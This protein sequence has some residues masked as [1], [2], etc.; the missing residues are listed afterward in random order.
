MSSLLTGSAKGAS[1]LIFIQVS[2]RALTFGINQV[3]LRYLSPELLGAS[4][5]LELYSISVLFFSRESLR[6]ALQR[7]AGPLQAIINISALPVLFAIPLAAWLGILYQR[8]TTLDAHDLPIALQIYG[9]A[10]L[11]ELLAEPCFAVVQ[12]KLAYGLRALAE[13]GATFARC[14]VTFGFVIWSRNSSND[15]GVLPFAFGQLAYAATLLVVYLVKTLPIMEKE[16]SSY[17]PNKITNRYVTSHSTSFSV[18]DVRS[19]QP[20]LIQAMFPRTVVT[21]AINMYLQSAVKYILTQGDSII[22]ASMASLSDQGAYALASN[23][24]GLIA[25]MLFQPIEESSRN[26]FAKLC[27]SAEATKA[28]KAQDISRA[29]EVLIDI[30]KVYNLLALISWA[31]GPTLAPKMLR[32]VAGTKWSDTGAGT[33][34]GIYCYYIPFLAANGVTEAFVSAVAGDKELQ[35]QSFVLVL[36]SVVF[37]LMAYVFLKFYEMGASG[38]VLANC[39]NMMFRTVWNIAFVKRYFKKNGNVRLAACSY[40]VK[41]LWYRLCKADFTLLGVQT[42]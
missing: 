34:L 41:T 24:G 39:C 10:T 32:V 2:S 42:P 7:H 15:A 27:A 28:S 21:T 29:K 16:R 40:G 23:Y 9:A 11:I 31:V 17:V 13:M 22:I 18:S 38:L 5:Q 20:D 8:S 6:V 35:Q 12:Q 1:Y 37:A 14:F 26:L 19:D 3:L 30:L 25:R 4:T 33:V 36:Y